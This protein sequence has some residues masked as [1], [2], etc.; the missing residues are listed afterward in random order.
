MTARLTVFRGRGAPWGLCFST[1]LPPARAFARDIKK[2]WKTPALACPPA[3]Q[4]TTP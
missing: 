2:A 4:G 3:P 1:T